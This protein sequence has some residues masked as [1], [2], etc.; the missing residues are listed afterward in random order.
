VAEK[1][2]G[3]LPPGLRLKPGVT[4][5]K[6][7]LTW[8]GGVAVLAS[9]SA[10]DPYCEPSPEGPGNQD[11]LSLEA[12]PPLPDGVEPI[13]GLT[14]GHAVDRFG[15]LTLTLSTRSLACGEVAGEHDY[16]PFDGNLG[17]S[18]GLPA[19]QA[20]AGEHPLGYPLHVQFETPVHR[21]VGGGGD[22]REASIE[23]FEIT[24]SCVTGRVKGLVDKGGPFDG[25][26][27]ALRCEP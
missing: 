8:V 14:V 1:I 12:C 19:R 9:T 3:K 16:C 7:I 22:I 20:V 24:D 10:C 13:E 27:R 23:I 4:R 2:S 5:L 26:F 15:G 11:P 25:G 18:V 6:R 21:N 17:L